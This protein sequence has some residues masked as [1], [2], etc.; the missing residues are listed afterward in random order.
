MEQNIS[1]L[2]LTLKEKRQLRQYKTDNP[3]ATRSQ[4]QQWSVETFGLTR[5]PSK[6]AITRILSD[7]DCEFDAKFLESRKSKRPPI[8]PDL[9]TELVNWINTCESLCLPIITHSVL[10]YKARQFSIKSNHSLRSPSSSQIN[11]STS[12]SK[13]MD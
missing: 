1:R 12:S 10:R 8:L 9:E 7:D 2:R 5:A 11:G 4:L 6:A 13:D 3:H